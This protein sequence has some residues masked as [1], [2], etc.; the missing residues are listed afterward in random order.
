M[1]VCVS[2]RVYACIPVSARTCTRRNNVRVCVLRRLTIRDA[3]I[4]G[5]GVHADCR[6]GASDATD[7]MISLFPLFFSSLRLELWN[8]DYARSLAQKTHSGIRRRD[9][10]ECCDDIDRSRRETRFA[11]EGKP[12][13]AISKS[14]SEPARV[15]FCACARSWGAVH[16]AGPKN[17]TQLGGV[18]GFR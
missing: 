6:N 16:S 14:R 10:R 12:F 18:V 15:N 1:A 9:A 13:D 3:G 5:R 7:K 17:T 2:P 11:R 4:Y 8:I